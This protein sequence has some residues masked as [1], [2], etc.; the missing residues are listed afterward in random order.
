LPF[1]C[2]LQRYTTVGGASRASEARSIAELAAAAETSP[3]MEEF[4]AAYITGG[5]DKKK[6]KGGNVMKGVSNMLG[7]RSSSSKKK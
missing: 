4:A 3:E 7:L 1:K 6:K 5:G 2:D